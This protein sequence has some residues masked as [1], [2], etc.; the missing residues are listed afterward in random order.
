MGRK[1][2]KPRRAGFILQNESID[3]SGK[4]LEN[5][6]HNPVPECELTSDN[7]FFVHVHQT[8]WVEITIHRDISEIVLTNLS[9][10][11]EFI[12]VELNDDEFSFRFRLCNVVEHLGRMKLGH[13]PV[14]SSDNVYLECLKKRVVDEVEICDVVFAG[15]FD[16]TDEGVS[17]LAHLVSL[18]FLTLRPVLSVR[19]SK[20]VSSVRF[21]VEI[22]QSAFDACESL[23]DNVRQPWKKSMMSVMAWVRP[24]VTTSEVRYGFH[25]SLEMDIYLVGEGDDGGS[26]ASKFD[27][28]RFYEAIKRSKDC[29]MLSIELLDLITELRPYQRRAAYWMVSREKRALQ[30]S[31]MVEQDVSCSPLCVVVN[32]LESSSRMFY[33]PFSGSVSL[34]QDIPSSYVSGGILADEMGLGKTVE[35]LACVLAHR[36]SSSE[37]SSSSESTSDSCL[38]EKISLKRVK[39]ERVECICGALTESYRYKGLWV[40]CDVC[41]AWQHAECVGYSPRK[42]LK[43]ARNG[44]QLDRRKQKKSADHIIMMEGEHVCQ[45][46]SELMQ[47]TGSAVESGATLIVCPAPIL[48]QWHAEILRH[49]KP[50]SLKT[51]VYEGVRDISLGNSPAM[52]INELASADI[53]LTT[54]DV[55]KDDLSHDSERHEGDRRLMR[56]EK[57]YPV[58]PTLLTRISWWRVC[59]DEAQMVESNVAPATEMALRLHT[60]HRWCITGTPVQRK[61]DDLYYLLR[62]LKASPFDV[63]RRWTEVIREP[64]ERR[65]IASVAFTHQLFRQ[66][67]WRSSKSHVADELQLPAQEEHVSWLS[68]S[69]VEEHFYQRQHESCV[70]VA[71]EVVRR[72]KNDILNTKDPGSKFS[73]SMPDPFITHLEAEKLLNSLLKLRQ[74]CCHPQVGGSGLRSLQHSPLT[75]EEVLSVLISKTKLE[76]EEALR[77]VVSSLN[78][79]AGIAILRGEPTNAASLY[80]EGLALAE[81]HSEDFRLDPL[82]NIHI[83]HNLAE[84]LKSASNSLS[85]KSLLKGQLSGIFEHTLFQMTDTSESGALMKNELKEQKVCDIEPQTIHVE[86]LIRICGSMKHKYLSAFYARLSLAQEEFQKSYTQVCESLSDENFKNGVWWLEALGHIEHNREASRELSQKIE[87]AVLPNK[88][89]SKASRIA[90]RFQS[91][92]SLKYYIQTGMDLL[93]ASRKKVLDNLLEIDQR[94]ENPRDEDIACV[95][96]CSGCFLNRDGP[97]CVHCELNKS[98]QAYEARLFLKQRNDGGVI[99]SAEEALELQKRNIERNTFMS[100]LQQNSTVSGKR[101]VGKMLV[102]SRSPSELEII[103]GVIR[104]YFKAQLGRQGVAEANSHLV[105]LEGMRKEYAHARSLATVQAQLLLAHDEIKMATS[106][107]RLKENDEDKSIDALS[108]E[109]LDVASIENS[110][111]KFISLATLSRIRGKLRY[112]QGLVISKHKTNLSSEAAVP[113]D[114]LEKNE[115]S[116]KT[117]VDMCPICQE[118]LQNQ[119]MV[120]Q[121]GHVTCC[122]CLFAISERNVGHSK[123]QQDNW[124]I[125]PTCRQRSDY[126][127]IAF[128]DDSPN[129]SQ[130]V[131]DENL[132]ASVSVRGSY[133]T[134]IEAITRRILWIKSTDQKA[135]VLVFSSWNDVLD[136]L[137]HAFVANEISYVRMKGGRR[138]SQTALSIFKGED[139]FVQVLLLLVQHGANGLNLLEA[140][141]VVLV[142][143][144]LNP[145]VEA[146]AISRVHRIGQTKET[147]IHR[148]MVK[149]T[150]EESLYKLN[151]SRNSSSF[152]SGNKKNQDQPVLTVKDVESLFAAVPPTSPGDWEKQ[153]ASLTNNDAQLRN[154]TNSN[155][156]TES[157][158]HLPPSVAA[159]I[160]AERRLGQSRT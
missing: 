18:K 22:L 43:G 54:Y 58:V 73:D 135:K 117:A 41:D 76:G 119:R 85:M 21:R 121:C 8:N 128:A 151:K 102:V 155:A 89:I 20:D 148:F 72:F 48:P 158:T 25:L 133:G 66:L 156:Q 88:T 99:E 145:A 127:S 131:R 95:R 29:P 35:L 42:K 4:I 111:E 84:I 27:V 67:M 32:F 110:S 34:Y 137:E 75:M 140:Q 109:E 52:D 141:H 115:I 57:R 70:D 108:L 51:C 96:D 10:T 107:L 30:D 78:G 46:C 1:K 62:F 92:S 104:S 47:A 143:P 61:L 147:L 90:S 139:K 33:N 118:T 77:K 55:L 79:L 15:Q 31:A 86:N 53:V 132:E 126:E 3:L 5:P 49:T 122:K 82:L 36:K 68:F 153:T 26:T 129:I 136:V 39:R 97:L 17:G 103:L 138:R 7:P 125:C 28:S 71:H 124:V 149:D 87:D 80:K 16:G 142:E 120:F 116:V 65:D 157:L 106:R 134:K 91:I 13:W 14:I 101:D 24:E 83:H 12:G 37:D 114:S 69:K 23:L 44:Q 64:Y 38:L 50:G 150:V 154:T 130:I 19:L 59:L 94:M 93:E 159:A 98:F 74:A 81:E 9:I 144:L 6:V 45:L 63:F 60:R 40:Q 146:Q 112:L 160:A 56:Y 100:N 123:N 11:D 2:Q 152:I 113:L 105:L